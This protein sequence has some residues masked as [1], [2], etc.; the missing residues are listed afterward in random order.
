MRVHV[1]KIGN[2][3]FDFDEPIT[4]EWIDEAL[5]EASPLRSAGAGHLKVHLER[6]RG[7]VVQARG[8]VRVSVKAD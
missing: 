7:S 4:E 1:D 6:K 5:G 2:D 3:G 8:T